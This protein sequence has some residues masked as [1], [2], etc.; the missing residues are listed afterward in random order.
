LAEDPGDGAV[1]PEALPDAEAAMNEN[2]DWFVILVFT[3]V[4][5]ALVVV[6]IV[7]RFV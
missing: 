1:E 4:M 6:G 2:R 3:V 5:L 7:N